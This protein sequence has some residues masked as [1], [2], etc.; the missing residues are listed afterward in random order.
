VSTEKAY[1]IDRETRPAP[2]R[3]APTILT[4]QEHKVTMLVGQGATNREAAKALFV[5]PKTI[6]FHLRSVY[7]KLGVRS[8]AELAHLIG[9]GRV[10]DRPA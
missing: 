5:S 4:S 3:C 6:E 9:Q 8:R 2:A 10:A 7:R 1:A